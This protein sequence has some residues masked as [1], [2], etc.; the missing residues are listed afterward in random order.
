MKVQTSLHFEEK[1]PF[2][3]ICIDQNSYFLYNIP[4]LQYVIILIHFC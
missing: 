2:T 3:L 4:Y 1:H